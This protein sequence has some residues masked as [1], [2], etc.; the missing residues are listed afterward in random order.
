MNSMLAVL[1]SSLVLLNA[2]FLDIAPPTNFIVGGLIVILAIGAGIIV[3]IIF[4]VKY[5]V[6]LKRKNKL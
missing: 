6:R 5:L 4:A 1:F 2:I 3:L